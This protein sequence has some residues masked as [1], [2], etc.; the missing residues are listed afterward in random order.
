VRGQRRLV[1]SGTRLQPT[2]EH[3]P[4][5]TCAACAFAGHICDTLGRRITL[6]VTVIGMAVP[7]ALI[8]CL[9]TF[10]HIGIAAPALLAVLRVLQG[11]AVGG[12]FGSAMVR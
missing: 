6:L 4:T 7:T 12:E 5:I 11:L 8:G 1:V 2:V 3:T 10:A 9:P